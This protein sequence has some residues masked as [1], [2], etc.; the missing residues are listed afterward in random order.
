VINDSLGEHEVLRYNPD[1]ASGKWQASQLAAGT[2]LLKPVP[3]FK[4]LDD[5]IVDLERSR[6]GNPG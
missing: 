2:N 3:L 5:E 6:L 4:K 1:K